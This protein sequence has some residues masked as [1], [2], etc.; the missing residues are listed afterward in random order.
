M[1][2][3]LNGEERIWLYPN[4]A[5]IAKCSSEGTGTIPYLV[6]SRPSRGW[7]VQLDGVRPNHLS[8]RTT[9]MQGDFCFHFWEE[10]DLFCLAG[11]KRFFA[12]SSEDGRVAVSQPLEFTDKESLDFLQILVST[13]KNKLIV[14]STKLGWLIDQGKGEVRRIEIPGLAESIAREG[15]GFKIGYLDTTNVDLAKVFMVV[16]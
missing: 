13:T 1:E 10:Q 12:I 16:E 8:P 6:V 3:L 15:N 11:Y 7:Q 4:D 2:A 5:V 14:V 9:S